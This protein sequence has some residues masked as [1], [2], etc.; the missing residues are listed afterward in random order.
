MIIYTQKK[1]MWS[2]SI[3][4][5]KIAAL[6]IFLETE[7]ELHFPLFHFQYKN[8]FLQL[9]SQVKIMS[10]HNRFTTLH[11]WSLCYVLLT[12]QNNCIFISVCWFWHAPTVQAFNMQISGRFVGSLAFHHLLKSKTLMLLSISM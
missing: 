11:M 3:W 10:T 2:V 1:E 5:K 6:K 8:I 4:T 9:N 12:N 7:H